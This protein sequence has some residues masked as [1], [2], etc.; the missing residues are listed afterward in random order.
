MSDVAKHA[1]VGQGTVYR[2]FENKRALLDHVLDRTVERMLDAVHTGQTASAQNRCRNS[3]TNSAR[4][5]R[6]YSR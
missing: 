5:R 4:S 1:G 6:G 2:Y 3:S